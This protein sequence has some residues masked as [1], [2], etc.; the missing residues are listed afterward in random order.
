MKV[1]RGVSAVWRVQNEMVTNLTSAFQER[2]LSTRCLVLTHLEAFLTCPSVLFSELYGSL[3]KACI[4]FHPLRKLIPIEARWDSLRDIASYCDLVISFTKRNFTYDTDIL[5]AFA[6]ISAFLESKMIK[7]E[8]MIYGLPS[9]DLI[10]AISWVSQGLSARRYT[11]TSMDGV[12]ILSLPS[13]SWAGWTGRKSWLPPFGFNH[14]YRC[15]HV[16]DVE[17]VSFDEDLVGYCLPKGT[18]TPCMLKFSATCLP[19]SQFFTSE[20]R[21]EQSKMAHPH[22]ATEHYELPS[23]IVESVFLGS[24]HRILVAFGV[25]M[26]ELQD[27]GTFLMHLAD[28]GFVETHEDRDSFELYPKPFDEF[29]ARALFR[30]YWASHRFLKI[31]LEECLVARWINDDCTVCERIGFAQIGGCSINSWYIETEQRVLYLS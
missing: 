25:E 27:R 26:E 17:I 3:P 1:V 8:R 6:G 7:P 21:S 15:L 9:T 10:L 30:G 31:S 19:T 13:W 2:I 29:E 11:C 14:S 4:R 20:Y 28:S 12:G 16:K 18:A 22:A 24:S 5:R 23:P